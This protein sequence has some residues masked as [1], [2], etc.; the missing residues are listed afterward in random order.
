M[1]A[2]RRLEEVVMVGGHELADLID[3]EA[4]AGPGQNRGR[5]A[6]APVD[7]G[8]QDPDRHEHQQTAP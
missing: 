6:E 1:I 3:E 5:H 7:K 2:P 8:Q 4:E